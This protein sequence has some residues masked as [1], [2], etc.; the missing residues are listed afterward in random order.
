MKCSLPEKKQCHEKT[1]LTSFV[2][3]AFSI[4]WCQ[5]SFI[6]W[7]GCQSNSSLVLEDFK[8]R[9]KQWY[10]WVNVIFPLKHFHAVASILTSNYFFKANI[11]VLTLVSPLST[12]TII[13]R[14]TSDICEIV[15]LIYIFKEL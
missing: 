7:Q 12:K 11:M 1:W 5:S 14:A 2:N 3:A 8:Q 13:S 9:L 4:L 10:C 15:A 6:L